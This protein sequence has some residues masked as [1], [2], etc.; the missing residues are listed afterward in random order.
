MYY[1][2]QSLSTGTGFN[3]QR[4]TTKKCWKIH[5]HCNMATPTS[6]VAKNSNSQALKVKV[7]WRVECELNFNIVYTI[8][9]IQD[10]KVY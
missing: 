2:P 5:F 3:S 6:S 7:W 10:L 4:L 1:T 8:P 9:S